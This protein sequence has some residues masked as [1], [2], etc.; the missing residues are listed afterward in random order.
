MPFCSGKIQTKSMQV[1]IGGGLLCYK[2]G[3]CAVIKRRPLLK[4]IHLSQVHVAIQQLFVAAVNDRGPVRR[5]KHVRGVLGA[6]LGQSYRLS[7]CK[8]V[9][10]ACSQVGEGSTDS[11]Q[12]RSAMLPAHEQGEIIALGT[13]PSKRLRT[14]GCAE[15]GI[16]VGID[17]WTIV[18]L[19]FVT[20]CTRPCLRS[21]GSG[22]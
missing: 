13:K 12:G 17:S 16:T 2:E 15:M 22:D 3:S 18:E 5:S 8:P 14:H 6:K 1:L 21:L 9:S 7:A 4:L 11:S 20:R 19:A 10:R